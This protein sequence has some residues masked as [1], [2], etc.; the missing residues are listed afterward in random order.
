MSD[1]RATSNRVAY[2]KKY[3]LVEDG[4]MRGALSRLAICAIL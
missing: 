3:E 1:I 4:T 2:R